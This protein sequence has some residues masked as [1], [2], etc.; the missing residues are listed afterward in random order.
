MIF[1]N[2]ENPLH[3]LIRCIFRTLI[4][5]A[6]KVMVMGKFQ[7]FECISFAVLLKL[8]KFDAREISAFYSSAL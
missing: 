3:F 4:F 1:L 2:V 7:K 8:R 6:D 5:Y